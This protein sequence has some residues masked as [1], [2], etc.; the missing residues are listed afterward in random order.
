MNDTYQ[1]QN[2]S[3]NQNLDKKRS[4]GRKVENVPV[5]YFVPVLLVG[6]VIVWKVR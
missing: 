1:Y 4:D 6:L 3:D 5:I 2:E